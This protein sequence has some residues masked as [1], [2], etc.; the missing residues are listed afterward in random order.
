MGEGGKDEKTGLKSCGK[1]GVKDSKINTCAPK[2]H[3][4]QAF[5]PNYGSCCFFPSTSN[6]WK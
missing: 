1:K 2:V 5:S 6:F 3:L 4:H